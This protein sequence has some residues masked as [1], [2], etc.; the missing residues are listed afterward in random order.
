MKSI[1]EIL[2]K[3]R[4]DDGGKYLKHEWQLFGYRLA[5]WLG[6]TKRISMY[7]KLAK[8]E[9]RE[10]LQ[11]AWDFVKD[12]NNPRSRA[13]LFMWKLAEIKKEKANKEDGNKNEKVD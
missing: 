11:D 12:A 7:M 2:N 4:N 13:G 9:K 1:A 8:N 10:I 6:D 5:T 3:I